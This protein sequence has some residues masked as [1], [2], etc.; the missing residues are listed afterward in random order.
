MATRLQFFLSLSSQI[1]LW[2]TIVLFLLVIRVC[3]HEQGTVPQMFGGLVYWT[4]V[5][6]LSREINTT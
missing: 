1:L 6:E 2:L 5:M 3:W 4:I